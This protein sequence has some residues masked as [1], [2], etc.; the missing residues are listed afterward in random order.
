MNFA[1]DGTLIAA[2]GAVDSSMKQAAGFG[3][4]ALG[5]TGATIYFFGKGQKRNAMI[6]G[7][8]AAACWFIGHQAAAK[9]AAAAATT[10]FT[11][12]KGEGIFLA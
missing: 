7:A 11:V 3:L 10:P 12:P 8:G 4:A 6:A 1:P 2:A 9:L 5:L